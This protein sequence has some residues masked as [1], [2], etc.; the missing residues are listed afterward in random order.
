[1]KIVSKPPERINRDWIGPA[2]G[3]SNLRPVKFFIPEDE[4]PAEKEYRQKRLE[5]EQWNQEFWEAHNYNFFKVILT[6]H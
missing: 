6:S 1:M 3:K 2:D 4:V 5:T